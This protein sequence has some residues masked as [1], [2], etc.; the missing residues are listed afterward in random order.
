MA[1]DVRVYL[2]YPRESWHEPGYSGKI[3]DRIVKAGTLRVSRAGDRLTLSFKGEK[4]K[5][6]C[7]LHMSIPVA[8]AVAGLV[9]AVSQGH[10]SSVE[11]SL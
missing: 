11:A 6:Q 8:I 9:T 2:G 3:G 5:D 4:D 10:T 7:T 1:S